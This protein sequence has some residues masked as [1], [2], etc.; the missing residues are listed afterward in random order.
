[1]LALAAVLVPLNVMLANDARAVLIV[2]LPALLELLNVSKPALLSGETGACKVMV[3]VPALLVLLK[4]IAPVAAL[5]MFALPAE[6]ASKKSSV[7]RLVI[8]A[9]P[10]VL[11]S[12]NCKTL[13]LVTIAVPAEL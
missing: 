2:A 6:V 4:L 9:V 3:A 8:S 5:V 11:V 13:L 1:M 10:P 12:L 7:A